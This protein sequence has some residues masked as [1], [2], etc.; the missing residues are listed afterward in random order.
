MP[1]LDTGICLC[2]QLEGKCHKSCPLPSSPASVPRLC[3]SQHQRAW[4]RGP[5]ASSCLQEPLIHKPLSLI[6][7]RQITG[8][9][10]GDRPRG[11]QGWSGENSHKAGFR[12]QPAHLSP[13]PQR[14]QD[15][16]L[17]QRT[18]RCKRRSGG[19]GWPSLSRLTPAADGCTDPGAS[20]GVTQAMHGAGWPGSATC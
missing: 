10:V 6:P 3:P 1:E 17:L 19:Q 15:F 13:F 20:A 18:P 16:S 8:L 14:D 4:Y 9:D 7:P 12:F 11:I 2:F 5:S